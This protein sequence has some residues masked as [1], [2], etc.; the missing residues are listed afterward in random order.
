MNTLAKA[1]GNATTPDP[2][3]FPRSELLIVATYLLLAALWVV[4]S[5]IALEALTG[6]PYESLQLQT[7]KGLNFV[8]ATAV[9]L[10]AVLRRSFSR[11]RRAETIARE[12]A[13]RFELVARA[14]NDAIWDWNL[15]TDALWWGAGFTAL[16]GYE[17]DEVEPTIESWSRRLHPED[18]ERVLNGIHRA[19][20]D[21]T[22]LWFDEYRFCR[23]D[24]AYARVFDKGFVIRGSD[25]TPVRMVGGIMDVTEQRTADE[26]IRRSQQQLR[27]L[28]ARLQSLR[29]EE[30]KRIA[31][32]IHD[33]LGQML[34]AL[35]MDLRWIENRL[36]DLPGVPA[37]N[38]IL[39][40]VVEATELTD[41]TILAVQ[42]IAGELR[43]AVL[44]SLGLIAA[45]KQEAR[46]FHDRTGIP[47][48]LSLPESQPAL[49]PDSVTAVFRIFQEALTNVTRHAKA[50]RV[51]IE[52]VTDS[53]QVV[54]RVSDDGKGLDESALTD[55]GSL[56]LLGMQERAMLVGGEIA[57]ES[58]EGRGTTMTLRVP[59]SSPPA[60][61]PS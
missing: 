45:L 60:N 33:E 15:G 3:H 49:P 26:K 1:D 40:R 50:K 21:G 20:K 57:F 5:D 46:R 41:Q 13:E 12:H 51:K 8:L 25:G 42:K 59:L 61:T 6:D 9:L 37:A 52:L 30:Q 47:H 29:E 16:F 54:L 11:R 23:K 39:D 31:R 22:R 10:Y 19:I 44:D 38:S 18:R 53:G 43:P 28:S 58:S 36:N 17:K 55:R 2:S 35:K 14:S 32:E 7:F 48:E 24:G 56:G 27:A 34:T 4:F